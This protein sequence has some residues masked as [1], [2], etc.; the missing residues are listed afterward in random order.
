MYFPFKRRFFFLLFFFFFITAFNANSQGIKF[1]KTSF[2]EIKAK[3]KKEKKLIFI[4]C[5]TTWCG[6]CTAM[7]ENT[8]PDPIAG[9]YFNKNFINAKI[10][11]EKGE[12]VDLAQQYE[13]GC[14][15]NLL[16]LDADG[17]VLHRTAGYMEVDELISFAKT[18]QDPINRFSGLKENY[19]KNKNNI[20]FVRNYLLYLGNTCLPTE[21]VAKQFLSI[22]KESDLNNPGN[23]PVI[24]EHGAKFNSSAYQYVLKNINSFISKHTRD[25]VR[26]YSVTAV[27]NEADKYIEEERTKEEF[28]AFL[29]S[30]RNM[31][32]PTI[33]EG[34]LFNLSLK[35]FAK[36]KDWKEYMATAVKQGDQHIKDEN[37]NDVCWIFYLHSDDPSALLKAESW[38]KKYV[39]SHKQD[40]EW[41]MG[42]SKTVPAWLLDLNI[43]EEDYEEAK[44]YIANKMIY[45]QYDTYAALHYKLKNKKDAQSY[46]DMAINVAKKYDLSY[47]STESL[48]DDIKKL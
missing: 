7:S 15:P 27:Y 11:M 44:T 17:K 18:A 29:N 6:P 47:E 32:N 16:I 25:S 31:K 9:E 26:K 40:Y 36:K 10:D 39:T 4:D 28:K 8:F 33:E 13:I 35:Y 43:G 14:Y 1:E 3:A 48:L 41:I 21:D 5:F 20:T 19:E 12:G 37:V 45:S 24:Y 30:V 34:D 46:A 22:A 23:W 38:M 2:S 42:I